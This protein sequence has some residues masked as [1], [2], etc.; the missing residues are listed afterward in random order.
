MISALKDIINTGQQKNKY[1]QTQACWSDFLQSQ[2][3]R[4]LKNGIDI[5]WAS[6]V[7]EKVKQL[8]NYLARWREA[9]GRSQVLSNTLK[10][11][12]V[13]CWLIIIHLIPEDRRKN[14]KGEIE[15]HY[16]L[17]IK[18]MGRNYLR[19]VIL[20]PLWGSFRINQ[21]FIYLDWTEKNTSWWQRCHLSLTNMSFFD[22]IKRDSM[23]QIWIKGMNGPNGFSFSRSFIR[24]RENMRST[25]VSPKGLFIFSFG[26]L[27]Y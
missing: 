5:Y 15:K 17:T 14:V 18:V 10:S 25:F 3:F 19:K 22:V 4:I 23:A 7:L 21:R 16:I 24:K 6:T 27:H 8:W 12:E 2:V 9:W 20:I 13:G 1:S 11:S 26:H